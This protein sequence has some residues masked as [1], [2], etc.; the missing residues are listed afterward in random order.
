M[1]LIVPPTPIGKDVPTQQAL[2]KQVVQNAMTGQFTQLNAGMLRIFKTLWQHPILTPQ[3]A[4]DAF[5]TDAVELFVIADA[6]AAL[7]N[8]VVPNSCDLT[9]PVAVTRNNDGTVTLGS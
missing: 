2:L 6:V 4:F 8:S 9:P 3:Q 1:A 7:L 5:G